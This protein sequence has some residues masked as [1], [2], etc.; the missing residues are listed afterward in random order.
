MRTFLR[1]LLIITLI[2]NTASAQISLVGL[3][4]GDA[5]KIIKYNVNT[6]SLSTAATLTTDKAVP[7][8]NDLV[9]AKNGLL[10][11]MTESG[12]VHGFGILFSF[13]PKANTYRKLVDFNGSTNGGSPYGSLVEGANGQLFGL[14]EGG[15]ANNHGT[16]FSFNYSNNII[17]VLHS[18]NGSNGRSPYGSLVKATNGLLYGMTESGGSKDMGTVFSFN[19]NNKEYKVLYS[20]DD[21]NGRSPYGSLIQATD[22]KLYGMAQF[23]GSTGFGVVFSIDLQSSSF[24][25]RAE[26]KWS[27]GAWPNSTLVQAANNKL[28][29]MTESGG[30]N[31]YGVL[32]EYDPSSNAIVAQT[33]FSEANGRSP[34]GKLTKASDNKLYGMTYRGGASDKGV[35]FSYDPATNVAPFKKLVDFNGTNGLN[36]SAS[37]VEL[38]ET[39]VLPLSLIS[40]T[41][42][43]TNKKV[44]LVWQVDREYDLD[45]YEIERSTDGI[46]FSSI[47]F[48]QALNSLNLHD[49]SF[50]DHQPAAGNNYYR[51]KIHEKNLAPHYSPI[52]L[53][54]M[55]ATA[56]KVSV[57]PN[58]VRSA[59]T[60]QVRIIEKSKVQLQ[61]YNAQGVMV[62]QWPSVTY[63]KGD[64]FI[65]MGL[66]NVASG[67]YVLLVNAGDKKQII[68]IVKMSGN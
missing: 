49:Y 26:F 45:K 7:W 31:N 54:H 34:Y 29:G 61:L 35:L 65:P 58:P 33:D 30:A 68:Q 38:K 27:N 4:R 13:D 25:K 8:Y 46:Q 66:S 37:M 3:T 11:G 28:Y 53:V 59:S 42:T 62:K 51:L 32:F 16:L 12:G 22:G 56:F 17:T 43:E 15:G 55:G 52:K 5:G 6:Q 64:H 48:V 19:P 23:G 10:Y 57:Q 47:G 21:A 18:F 1:C 67:N 39:S 44:Q 14:T 20:F 60:I 40:F 63:E 50:M 36:P 24:A 41:A 9:Q 2:F